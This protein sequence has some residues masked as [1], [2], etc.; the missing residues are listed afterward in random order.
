MLQRMKS[1]KGFTL[2]ELLIVVAIIAVLVAIAVPLFVGALD[3]AQDARDD[4]NI[5][6][7]KSAAVVYILN[8]TKNVK[9]NYNIFKEEDG[10]ATNDL[11]EFYTVEATVNANGDITLSKILG[12]STD[13]RKGEPAVTDKAT[14]TA[15][16]WTIT[17]VLTTLD[18]KEAA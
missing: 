15:T 13:P 12:K 2:A 6:S 5:R 16:G 3:K 11:Y 4:A 18:L 1:K 8:A 7:V 17:A 14:S 9:D 10:T